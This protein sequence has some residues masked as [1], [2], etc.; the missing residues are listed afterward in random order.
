MVSYNGKAKTNGKGHRKCQSWIESFVEYTGNLESAEEF[1]TWAAITTIASALEQH[2][3]MTTTGT[4]YP[5]IYCILVGQP[6]IGKTRTISTARTFLE[7]LSDL[8]IGPTSMTGASLVDALCASKRPIHSASGSEQWQNSMVLLPDEWAAF[9]PEF[10]NDFIGNLTTFYDVVPYSQW[11][12][13]KETKILIHRPQINM[14]CGSTPSNLLTYMPDKAWHQGFAS[15][16][17]LIYSNKRE[18]KDDFD[19]TRR[20]RELPAEM[21]QDLKH[22]FSLSGEFKPDGEFADL[23]N[24]WRANKEA[25]KPSHPKLE[26]YN[27]RRRAHLY[28]LAMVSSVDRGNSLALTAVDFHRALGWLEQAELSM[29]LI[30]DE[31]RASADSM[32]MDE[33][34]DY[35]K[36]HSGLS[37]TALMT[38]A[39]RRI[40][41]YQLTK[42]IDVLIHSGRIGYDAERK[43]FVCTD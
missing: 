3:H 38:Y 13:H 40:P 10:G 30:F 5:N 23:V 17:M 16:V 18:V 12:R 29:H 7:Q 41:A 25:P 4:L 26:H 33:I 19:P 37:Q 22:V 36:R 34:V 20:A 11:R 2:C 8:F 27:T 15:R 42:V 24:A 35:V 28:K 14:L 32:A 6:G 21:V 9:T 1:R 39:Q 43:T 31:G